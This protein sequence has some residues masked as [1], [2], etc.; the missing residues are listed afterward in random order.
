M[1][2]ILLI[3]AVL[4][5]LL[6]IVFWVVS[7]QLHPTTSP[8]QKPVEFPTSS[9]SP[10]NGLI[11]IKTPNSGVI[12]SKNFLADPKTVADPV[13]TG[14]YYLGNNTF[15]DQTDVPYMIEYIAS[16]QYFNIEIL[17][18]PLGKTRKDAEQYLLSKLGIS[19]S[20]L[21]S[22]DYMLSVPNSVSSLYA[23]TNLGFSFCPGAVQ[24]P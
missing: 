16:T 15:Q 24:L 4:I 17:Q 10:S 23:G 11:L 21:C 13:N 1:K 8:V 6:G 18:E 14:Y 3:F 20:Q 9:T 2:K 19:E 5:I 12:A 22:L 7:M